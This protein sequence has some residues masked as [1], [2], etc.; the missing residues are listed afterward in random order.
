MNAQIRRTNAVMLF[1]HGPL[2]SIVIFEN[3]ADGDIGKILQGFFEF[4]LKR[5]QYR[6]QQFLYP[7][8]F[9]FRQ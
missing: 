3:R 8:I 7:G 1:L 2:I 9:A 4:P 6:Y 5:V